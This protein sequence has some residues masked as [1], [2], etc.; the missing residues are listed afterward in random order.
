L[1]NELVL[2]SA[3]GEVY[4]YSNLGYA[5]LGR[6]IEA[7]SG[8]A[9]RDYLSEHVF[10]P[11]GM[12]STGW[13]PQPGMAVGYFRRGD[14]LVPEPRPDDGEFAP[15]GGMYSSLQDL[16]RYVAFQL[17][18][19]A[20]P[21]VPDMHPLRGASVRELHR[22]QAW[23]RWGLDVPVAS[24][25]ATGRL[26]LMAS[27]YGFGWVNSTTCNYEGL[28]Q[29]GGFEPGYS[30]SIALLPKHRIGFVTLA[31]TG[32][33]RDRKTFEAA[34]GLLEDGG[35][36]S[37]SEPP[38][39]A[40]LRA[41]DNVNRLLQ[42]WDDA[43]ARD[44]FDETS[45]KYSWFSRISQDLARLSG[46][47]GPCHPVGE[48]VSGSKTQLSWRMS[49]EHGRIDLSLW[50]TPGLHP[51]VQLLQWKEYPPPGV[52]ADPPPAPAP[53]ANGAACAE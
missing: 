15:A 22:G 42:K 33:I 29:H 34:L 51:S 3:P 45:L 9:F 37:L 18:A 5:L 2:A 41:H 40:L 43:L 7:V 4:A 52:S 13:Q 24:R 12:S 14:E 36:L 27:N 28:I 48:L 23:M 47:H 10:A 21:F 31:A 49:C 38:S 44:T 35:L 46:E 1:L 25:D 50:L 19:Y 11:L 53:L 17:S 26:S 6:V 39:P 30:A 16:S 32:G 8:Q 20:E